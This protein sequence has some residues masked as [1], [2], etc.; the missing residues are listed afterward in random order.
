MDRGGPQRPV[1]LPHLPALQGMNP[2]I[3]V[4]PGRI[5]AALPPSSP[6]PVA[7]VTP[8]PGSRVEGGALTLQGRLP[9]GAALVARP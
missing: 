7:K 6:P 3:P 5:R 2:G 1:P 8:G 4:T 9:A